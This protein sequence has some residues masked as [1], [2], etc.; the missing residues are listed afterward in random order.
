MHP[1]YSVIFFTTA[2]GAGYGLWFWLGL[3][4]A[5]EGVAGPSL[6]AVAALLLGGALVT[7]GLLS[8]TLHLGHP[9]RA[10]R[11]L[12]QWRSSWLSREGVAAVATYL[13]AGAVFLALALPG[14]LP[15]AGLAA[16][17][18]AAGSAATVWCTGMIYGSLRTIP[19]W[20]DRAVPFG[21]L[22]MAG[23]TGALLFVLSDTVFRN[24][25]GP[26]PAVAGFALVMAAVMKWF[27]WRRIDAA[28]AAFG[29]AEALGVPGASEIRT[30]DPPHTQPNF[31]MREM[32]YAVARRHARRLRLLAISF[33]MTLPLAGLVLASVLP[34][35]ALPLQALAVVSAGLGVWI[36]RWLFF[37]EAR[38][39][40]MLYYGAG[41]GQPQEGA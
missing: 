37:A 17:L 6:P 19:A 29:M 27:Y 14:G 3:R 38:H 31:V 9:E 16:A 23:A 10:W 41:P 2:S 4:L 11:A 39:V 24:E 35:L 36:E 15:G 18:L 20:S 34:A 22:A 7:L 30:L 13:P 12:G 5:V 25:A 28:P 33:L 32:G 26:W 21:Y 8:S 1:A 40:S